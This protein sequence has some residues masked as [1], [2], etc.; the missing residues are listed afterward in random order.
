MKKLLFLL[1]LCGALCTACNDN[2]GPSYNPDYNIGK[3]GI[4]VLNEGNYGSNKASVDFF[5]ADSGKYY[6]DVYTSANPDLSAGLGDVGNDIQ[7]Y[8]SKLYIVVNQSHKVEVCDART[9][10]RIGQVNIPSPRNICFCG[11]RAYVSSYVSEEVTDIG[12]KGSVYELDTAS[13]NITRTTTVGYNPEELLCVKGA[14][15]VINSGGYLYPKYD[16]TLMVV[17]LDS[18][19]V[20]ATVKVCPDPQKLRADRYGQ[21]WIAGNYLCVV[22]SATGAVQN[23]KNIVCN[24]MVA[25]NDQLYYYGVTYDEQYQGTYNFGTLNVVSKEDVGGFVS[26]EL[27][28]QL[29]NPYCL[30]VNYYTG[31]I[32]L[33]DAKNYTSNGM[34]YCLSPTGVLKWQHTTGDIPGHICNL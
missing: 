10:K 20:Q 22:N 23:L 16:S 7:V 27:K 24:N 3:T 33:T 19:K 12:T 5:N 2:D 21:L 9:C 1:L 31:D 28:A 15:Y 11:N 4:Y 25:F 17:N 29:Q 13:L 32:Y 14:L 6:R 30:M 8:G 26:A 18:F 34:I